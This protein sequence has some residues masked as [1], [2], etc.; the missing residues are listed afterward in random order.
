MK[1]LIIRD[2]AL[3][4]LATAVLAPAQALAAGT[5]DST[6]PPADPAS[7]MVST[8]D[9]YNR[10][11]SGAAAA[12][13]SG[14]F[15]EPA[16]RPVST[17]KSLNDI[18]TVAPKVDNLTGAVPSDVTLDKTYWSLRTDSSWG[19][20]S[21]TRTPAKVPRSG[22]TT[23]VGVP[24][25]DGALK[26]GVVWPN[27]R[28]TDNSDGTVT[29]NLT[30]LLWLKDA[31]CFGGLTWSAALTAA[32]TLN[33]G[34]CGLTD[35]SAEGNWRVPQIA[36]LSSLVDY[37]RANPALPA[38]HPFVEVQGEEPDWYWSSTTAA[39]DT[40]GAWCSIFALG[41]I[42]YSSK[43]ESHFVWPVRGGQ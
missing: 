20:Q 19:L 8:D 12:K 15:E 14:A 10:L 28:F 34:E 29:D 40:T 33:S 41:N 26:K 42:N 24:G 4:G 22:K 6:A 25:E 23:T 36:E 13:R 38:A 35:G 30:G 11:H 37:G 9:I 16:A 18:M 7:A 2:I 32:G 5:L 3:L 21:G 43:T 1:K 27:P 31:D 17:G 39:R